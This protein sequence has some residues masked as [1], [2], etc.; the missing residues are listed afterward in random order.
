[1]SLKKTP[2][3]FRKAFFALILIGLL[4]GTFASVLDF[5]FVPSVY[6]TE[7][8]SDGFES[9]DL[10]AW[11]GNTTSGGGS[12]DASSTYAK[13]GTYSAKATEINDAGDKA[14]AYTAVTGATA[15]Y[16]CGWVYLDSLTGQTYHS[17]GIGLGGESGQNLMFTVTNGSNWGI[18]YYAD[19]SWQNSWSSITVSADTWYWVV[20]YFYTHSLDGELKLWIDDVSAVNVTEVDNNDNGDVHQL[21]VG[22]FYADY[23]SQPDVYIDDAQLSD[24]YVSA[25]SEEEESGYVTVSDGN[26]YV[27]G[28]RLN[29][30]GGTVYTNTTHANGG[31]AT[32]DAATT[33]ILTVEMMDAMVRA[34]VNY[35][36]LWTDFT[37]VMNTYGTM[38]EGYLDT[39]DNFVGNLSERKVYFTIC[40][41]LATWNN[42]PNWLADGVEEHYGQWIYQW[43]E[44]VMQA[45]ETAW[46]N[47]SQRYA[48]EPYFLGY[49]PF[50]EGYWNI[51][52]MD[53][54]TGSDWA[55]GNMTIMWNKWLKAEYGTIEVLNATWDTNT[56]SQLNGSETAFLD[57]W[58]DSQ[59][60][61]YI[62]MPH[63]ISD[64]TDYTIETDARMPDFYHGFLNEWVRNWTRRICN[65]IEAQDTNHLI[66]AG[67]PSYPNWLGAYAYYPMIGGGYTPQ[68]DYT[69]AYGGG[70]YVRDRDE[71][72]FR[73]WLSLAGHQLE[74]SRGIGNS[75]AF[76]SATQETG[77]PALAG[78]VLGSPYAWLDNSLSEHYFLGV[79]GI[80]FFAWNLEAGSTSGHGFFNSSSMWLWDR[81]MFI[82]YWADAYKNM[83]TNR[84]SSDALIIGY[85]QYAGN[86]WLKELL[87]YH[88]LTY[89][90]TSPVI[91]QFSP[92]TITNGEWKTIFILLGGPVTN[93]DYVGVS[94]ET[95][96]YAKQWAQAESGRS[97][98]ILSNPWNNEKGIHGEYLDYT[99]IGYDTWI[100][101]GG[102]SID[103]S[104]PSANITANATFADLTVGDSITLEN[105]PEYLGGFLSSNLA[106]DATVLLNVTSSG[107]EDYYFARSSDGKGYAWAHYGW[108]EI[109]SGDDWIHQL[110]YPLP[111]CWVNVTYAIFS[112]LGLEP[113]NKTYNVVPADNTLSGYASLA[114]RDNS[115]SWSYLNLTQGIDSESDYAVYE[116]N[117]HN[118]VTLLSVPEYLGTFEGSVISTSWNL[119]G[120]KPYQ[121]RLLRFIGNSTMDYV[122]LKNGTI[123]DSEWF[124]ANSTLRVV[125]RGVAGDSAE[126]TVFCSNMTDAHKI[127]FSNGTTV[128]ASDY[129]SYETKLIT[130]PFTYSSDVTI[131][132][133]D[134]GGGSPVTYYYLTIESATGG[135][136]DPAG[137]SEYPYLD[138]SYAVVEAFPESG[139]SL[140]TPLWTLDAGDGGSDNPTSVLMDENHTILANFDE[141]PEPQFSSH[142][143]SSTTH[144]TFCDFGVTVTDDV[145]LSHYIFSTN[146]TGVWVN[147]TTTAFASNPQTVS[148]SK[149]LNGSV[150]V[151]VQWLWY[152][153]DTSDNW[154]TSATQSLVT[155]DDSI[156]NFG[157]VTSN[158][159]VA[160]APVAYSCIMGDDVA[161]SGYIGSWNN[162]G[163]WVNGTWTSG[164]TGTLSGTHNNTVGYVISVLFYAN[165][166][167]D[168]WG[169]SDQ[170]NFTLTG[171]S[172][173]YQYSIDFTNQMVYVQLTYFGTATPIESES[174]SFAGA[175][176]TTN[177]TGWT[178]FSLSGLSDF[179]YNSTAYPTSYPN[180]NITVPLAKKTFVIE[181]VNVSNTISSLSYES[182]KSCWSATG[183]GATSFK[184]YCSSTVYYLKI[185]GVAHYEGDGWSKTG[186]VVTVTDNLGSSH[187]YVLGLSVLG[188][189]PGG[190]NLPSSDD[191]SD[192][193]EFVTDIVGSGVDFVLAH[194]F[195][196]SIFL[197]FFVL[198]C[199]AII[200]KKREDWG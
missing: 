48:D 7:I 145:D 164:S 41:S 11:S 92:E 6:A 36:R 152:A 119:T 107:D 53:Y 143:Y 106:D 197:V 180:N 136:T 162:T 113:I 14:W 178:E 154:G 86:N 9:G 73:A 138:G 199:V 96:Y 87:S 109:K 64:R 173:A 166:T 23:G 112:E 195:W 69:D 12:I 104:H 129:Y 91:G 75:S 70:S 191:E 128:N 33:R 117:C 38:T 126:L 44:T 93:Q 19:S 161:V 188:S 120:F 60:G 13:N 108:R 3:R 122:L 125:T 10:S 82:T 148:I 103:W 59:T 147:G 16:G 43:N 153:N 97:V 144:V 130:I 172:E 184:I 155:T 168:N 94:N 101:N 187:S 78:G 185:N 17:A 30:V 63:E 37:S 132:V 56:W 193:E 84:S 146:N 156:P 177:A 1:M 24:T 140:A 61:A 74:I 105:Q 183:S 71:A 200:V 18:R 21:Q 169:V 141:L 31:P 39:L 176:D 189:N 90:E 121:T 124:T 123:D 181:A 150:G 49:I 134:E 79:D 80:S 52:A 47:L 81:A 110:N 198:G 46:G 131:S 116:L 114:S 171:D 139:Y 26:F 50:Y 58:G 157:Y 142:T 133:Y 40:L 115:V 165:D 88:G 28:T 66:L 4:V 20:V 2:K 89:D 163:T 76:P 149:V 111:E 102:S 72:N 54:M 95:L 22:A 25:P 29:L 5:G 170:Y 57:S 167:S 98:C 135:T 85:S 196:I 179:S 151:T 194:W 190:S 192:F 99:E 118:N 65:A 100:Y 127:K 158:T 160:N 77:G 32:G 159:T 55:T 83:V 68:E 45:Y 34:G 35:V 8:F 42:F 175:S 62:M 27:D 15:Y 174:C 137:G 186:N 51:Y 182:T 67:A